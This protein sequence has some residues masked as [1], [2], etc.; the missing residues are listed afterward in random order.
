M[1][2]EFYKEVFS[3]DH[4][5]PDSLSDTLFENCTF[6]SLDF[7]NLKLAHAKFIDC[8]FKNC[9][10][11]NATL[12][13]TKLRSCTFE[14][15]KLLGIQW[16]HASDFS[17]PTFK[18][19]NLSYSNFSGLN[20]K[21]NKFTNCLMTDADFSGTDLSECDLSNCD[22]LNARFQDTN[23]MKAN[24]K[25]A[26]N[27]SIDPIQNKVKGAKFSLPEAMGLLKGLGVV[28]IP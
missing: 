20:L 19:S 3:T 17:D 18:G 14:D 7:K 28:I 6:N 16:I 25:G 27:Y 5:L 24:F 8:V 12:A 11:S 23:L 2:T 13:H 26:F 21:K 10:F 22:F 4:P 9:D 1:S 15:S